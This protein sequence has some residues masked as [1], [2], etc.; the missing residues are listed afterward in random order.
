MGRLDVCKL[1]N[2]FKPTVDQPSPSDIVRDDQ[3]ISLFTG[4]TV[5]HD[6][7]HWRIRRDVFN[8]PLAEDMKLWVCS[9]PDTNSMDPVFDAGHKNL[10]VWPTNHADKNQLRNWMV[11]QYNAGNRDIAVYRNA[12]TYA[13]HRISRI[14]MD[15][16]GRRWY[17]KGDNNAREDSGYARDS[18][19]EW[20]YIGT[21]L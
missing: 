17:F 20:L 4:G 21:I 15:K 14:T 9:I 16:T 19:I 8:I 5:Y 10:Y 11:E 13:V 18:E 1:T 6:G 3:V 2:V 7:V 12:T